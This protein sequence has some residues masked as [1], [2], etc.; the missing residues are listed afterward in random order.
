MQPQLPPPLLIAALLLLLLLAP[1]VGGGRA[2]PGS[3]AAAHAAVVAAGVRDT[4]R[5]VAALREAE[6]V[7]GRARPESTEELTQQLEQLRQAVRSDLASLERQDSDA[8]RDAVGRYAALAASATGRGVRRTALLRLADLYSFF[9][10]WNRAWDALATWLGQPCPPDAD[11]P[12]AGDAD[13]PTGGRGD[14]QAANALAAVHLELA[15]QHQ[16]PPVA[17]AAAGDHVAAA[18]VLLERVVELEPRD[19]TAL[20]R[21]AYLHAR[22]LTGNATAV[23]YPRAALLLERAR[24]IAVSAEDDTNGA[25]GS[26]RGLLGDVRFWQE[27]G[28]AYA[29]MNDKPAMDAVFKAAADRYKVFPS[30]WQRPKDHVRGLTAK[31]FWDVAELRPPAV[32]SAVQAMRSEWRAIREEGLLML[33]A[34]GFFSP[35]P[36]RLVD[37]NA[38]AGAVHNVTNGTG[39]AV[40]FQSNDQQVEGVEGGWDQLVLF[41]HGVWNHRACD[42]SA[43]PRTCAALRPLLQQAQDPTTAAADAPGQAKFSLLRPGTHILPHCGPT[44]ARLRIHLGEYM[45]PHTAHHTTNST[46]SQ[47]YLCGFRRAERA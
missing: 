41:D 22:P 17:A 2:A 43:A 11:R 23:D 46:V 16:Q 9:G 34:G 18:R 24:T 20:V 30:R 4:A 40:G 19:L 5:A 45:Y 31:P 12:A 10:D 21:L 33:R 47:G 1:P 38:G 42:Q 35:E 8:L 39:G 3:V 26:S 25:G 6:A 28:G 14:T 13:L 29:R 44:N 15:G 27:L 32:V 7:Y 37:T 36:E